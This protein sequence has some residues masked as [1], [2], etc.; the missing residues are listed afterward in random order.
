MVTIARLAET[1]AL[2]G[3]PARTAMLYAMMDGRAFTAGELAGAAGVTP[4]TASGHLAQL[5]A[6]GMLAAEKQGR[7]RYF[8]LASA[9]IGGILEG[10]MTVTAA[11][12]P[13]ATGPADPALRRA[14]ICY[15]H[16]AGNLGVALYAALLG[17]GHVRLAEDGVALTASGRALL[18]RLGIGP[19]HAR[20]PA[21]RTCLDW[22][23]RRHH[24]AGQVGAAICATALAR[25]WLRRR[26]GTRALDVTPKGEA[27]FHEVFGVVLG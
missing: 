17:Q 11:R 8:R 25:D 27:G 18:D 22:S 7:H 16:I 23:E 6:A 3:D 4:Q 20:R 12:V 5:L 1:A 19:P 9:E 21:C 2:I 26:A 14:R 13:L 15:D 10:L 24:L